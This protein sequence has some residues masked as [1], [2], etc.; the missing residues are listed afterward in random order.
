MPVNSINTILYDGECRYCVGLARLGQRLLPEKKFRLA[1]LQSRP[2]AGDEGDHGLDEFRLLTASGSAFGGADALIELGRQ[3]WWLRPFRWVGATSSG[4][5]L[6]QRAYRWVAARRSC[7]SNACRRPTQNSP[8]RTLVFGL[9]A[10]AV[11]TVF[12]LGLP[13]W[14]LMWGL[15]LAIY[16]VAKMLTLAGQSSTLTRRLQYLFLWVGMDADT[17]LGPTRPP[18]PHRAEWLAALAKTLIGVGLLWG[19]ARWMST[20]VLAGWTGL[21]GLIFTLHFGAFHLLSLGWRRLGTDA[22]PIMQNPILARSVGEFWGQRWNRGFTDLVRTRIFRAALR[23]LG[24]NLALLLVFLV[25]GLI[26]EMVISVPARGG[27]GWPTA[28]FAAQ[29]AAVVLE[30]RAFHWRPTLRRSWVARLFTVAVTALP[31]F[32]LFHPPFIRRVVLPMLTALHAL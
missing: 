10:M 12:L 22:R 8:R 20:P 26:H 29:G 1:T 21:L 5:R 16:F 28:Y 15:A 32:W 19:C 4:R 17:I 2:P 7:R 24:P 9:G 31:A 23:P 11:L 30:R 3:V 14:I 6:L 25:S 13:P 18:Q 27:F